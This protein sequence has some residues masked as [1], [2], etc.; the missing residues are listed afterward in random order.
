ML[1][2]VLFSP[3][4][5]PSIDKVRRW[6]ERTIVNNKTWL[7]YYATSEE[8]RKSFKLNL[9]LSY[10][11]THRAPHDN[12]FRVCSTFTSTYCLLQPHHSKSSRHL[13]LN[14]IVSSNN[15][16]S[17]WASMQYWCDVEK[18][19]ESKLQ[20][21]WRLKMIEI[22]YHTMRKTMRHGDEEV[23]WWA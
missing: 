5:Q 11:H 13:I 22:T 16:S 6:R 20:L 4:F 15:L 1:L 7:Q 3:S 12:S 10:P 8:R 14:L 18:K 9:V 21:E 17:D 19:R 2:S 23:R